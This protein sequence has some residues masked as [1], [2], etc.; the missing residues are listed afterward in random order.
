MIGTEYAFEL[1]LIG[2]TNLTIPQGENEEFYFLITIKNHDYVYP[3]IVFPSDEP[4]NWSKDK[5][6]YVKHIRAQP[7][8]VKIG[9][10]REF[11]IRFECIGHSERRYDQ[12]N[13]EV[14]SWDDIELV[15][16]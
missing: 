1:Q 2:A 7:F 15:K 8:Y 9:E 3:I 6:I 16:L 13:V 12:Y 5:R 4:L 14:N 11:G 10:K